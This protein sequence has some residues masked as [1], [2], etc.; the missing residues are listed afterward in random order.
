MTEHKISREKLIRLTLSRY[1]M[2]L[3]FLGALFFLTAGTFDYWEA[4][5]YLGIIFVPM[6]FVMIY[7]IRYNPELL[8]RRMRMRERQGE[9][10][11]IIKVAIFVMAL[12]F[13]LPGL[14]RRFG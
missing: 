2:A 7:L 5:L 8:E 3:L 6:L 4:W 13:V 10:R 12:A 1:L 11:L 9:Q 14:D